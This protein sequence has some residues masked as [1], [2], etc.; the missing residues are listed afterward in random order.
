[1]SEQKRSRTGTRRTT[2]AVL[3]ILKTRTNLGRPISIAQIVKQLSSE[4]DIATSRDS[5]KAI[6]DDLIAYYPGP[7]QIRCKE[8]EKGRPYC[9]RLLLS[10]QAAGVHP[11]K[12]PDH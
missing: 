9:F 10:D 3:E 4:Y 6:L 7:D 12:H 11:G 1:M 5:V 8:S 2:M